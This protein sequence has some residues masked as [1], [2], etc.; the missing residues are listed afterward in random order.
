M[1]SQ[2][3]IYNGALTVLGERKLDTLAENREPRYKLDD[4]WSNE[5]IDRVLQHGQWN[6]ATR[7]A[8]IEASTTITPDFGYQ[9]AFEKPDDFI[10]TVGVNQDE[11]FKQPLTQYMDEARTWFADLET[12]YVR[13]VSNDSQFGGDLSLWPPNFTEYVEHYLAYK[14]AP[15]LTGLSVDIDA[16]KKLVDDRLNDAQA[17]DAM[18]Q[19]AKFPPKGSW[20]SSRQ[21]FRSGE[22]GKRNQLIG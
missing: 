17:T 14:V 18:E 6:F 19:P 3:S 4:V 10:R 21:G 15:R 7:A 11:Y 16:L 13:Y 2:K 9:S 1:P 12:L 20:A 22:R 5:F 8:K